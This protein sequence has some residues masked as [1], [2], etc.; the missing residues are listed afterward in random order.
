MRFRSGTKGSEYGRG[1]GW[2]ERALGRAS[3]CQD[4]RRRGVRRPHESGT[5]HHGVSSRGERPGRV[6]EPRRPHQLRARSDRVRSGD[7]SG[8]RRCW[9]AGHGRRLGSASRS[10]EIEPELMPPG[11]STGGGGRWGCRRRGRRCRLIQD[12]IGR[13]RRRLGTCRS[14]GS[15]SCL[16]RKISLWF[17]GL[18]FWR[19][20]CCPRRGRGGR[21][22]CV[23]LRGW[24]RSH[25]NGHCRGPPPHEG[26]ERVE[27][28]LRVGC[29]AHAG[30][31]LLLLLLLLH[32]RPALVGRPCWAGGSCAVTRDCLPI[33][34]SRHF[35]SLRPLRRR[36]SGARR[37]AAAAG[38]RCCS[39][40]RGGGRVRGREWRGWARGGAQ[41][42]AGG[43]R[44]SG[45]GVAG[46]AAPLQLRGLG[47]EPAIGA[48]ALKGWERRR[49]LGLVVRGIV[50]RR[51]V[52]GSSRLRLR[53]ALLLFSRR[54]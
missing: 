7:H 21:R 41:D 12:P 36:A 33:S 6:R 8:H 17:R 43:P 5:E 2:R 1:R 15:V 35:A 25:C 4:G 45:V 51:A 19:L 28:L 38:A 37:P 34:I 16:L 10:A 22:R 53:S 18:G 27:P 31:A 30:P 42:G 44:G 13:R 52:R 14:W 32:L 11:A 9:D 40:C 39:L 54:S 3:L 20:L 26:S 50:W 46:P 47:R 29:P 49:R 24:R 23:V 48:Q